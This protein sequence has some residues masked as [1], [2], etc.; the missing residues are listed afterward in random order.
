MTVENIEKH[1]ANA[2]GIPK[3][4]RIVYGIACAETT[5]SIFLI[6]SQPMYVRVVHGIWQ[7]WGNP[8]PWTLSLDVHVFTALIFLIL[9]MWQVTLGLLQKPG[10][11]A[12]KIHP[13]LGRIIFAYA[14]I[15][16][17]VAIWNIHVR[18]TNTLLFV[19]LYDVIFFIILFF[20]NGYIAIRQKNYLKHVDSMV[21]VFI[22]SGVAAILRIIYIDFVLM[23][24]H[25]P[26]SNAFLFLITGS[27]L[28]G[29]LF[30]YYALAG[31]LKYN[32]P[33]VFGMT[34]SIIVIFT[35]FPWH[36][37]FN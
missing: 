35:I 15:F 11:T 30:F 5:L 19:V 1:K 18:V 33:I 17:S 8:F 4:V 6:F 16:L 14:V 26:I 10:N 29:K 20:I 31:R 2:F 12:N 24:G 25:L 21:G 27:I 23:Y 22:F 28:V 34:A 7:R 3:R 9:M 32:I 37:Y 36:L 13:I